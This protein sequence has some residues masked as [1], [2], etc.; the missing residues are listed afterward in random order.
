MKIAASFSMGRLAPK[1]DLNIHGSR[2][3]SPNVTPNLIKNDVIL[4][5]H[6][7]T[8]TGAYQSIDEYTDNKLQPYIDQ[9]N[10]KQRRQNRCITTGYSEWHRSNGTLSQGK[11]EL[12]YEA[13]LQYGT[14]EDLGG[15]YYNPHT[16]P[17]RKAELRAQFERVYRDWVT[18]LQRDFPHMEVVYAVIHFS[19][20]E[21]TPHCHVCLQPLADCTRGLAKQVSIGRALAQDGIERLET[22]AEAEEAGGFQLAGF[23]RHFHHVY[24]NPTLEK[25]GYT[26]KDPY[27][28]MNNITYSGELDLSDT[29]TIDVPEDIICVSARK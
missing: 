10:A 18:D 17:E 23:Y 3:M 1:H 29:K 5:D 12:A 15:E 21:G 6:L 22:R 8:H 28:R 11:G 25:L 2:A 16:A 26:I 19:E 4:V 7:R 9:Y 24:Q 13:V 20:V 14:H 27:L